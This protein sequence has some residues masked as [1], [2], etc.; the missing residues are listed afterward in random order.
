MLKII[1]AASFLFFFLSSCGD[2][3]RLEKCK[4]A[5]EQK[6]DRTFR[7]YYR[8]LAADERQDLQRFVERVNHNRILKAQRRARLDQEADA[9]LSSNK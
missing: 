4:E 9:L 3:P 2:S 6:D 1:I 7:I 5:Y 8:T